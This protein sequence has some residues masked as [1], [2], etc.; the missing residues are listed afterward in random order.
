MRLCAMYMPIDETRLSK[1]KLDF[2]P[3]HL[4]FTCNQLNK[5]T[6]VVFNFNLVAVVP[7]YNSR[8]QYLNKMRLVLAT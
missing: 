4:I 5:A 3:P 7:N 2:I 8:V 1:Y 6:R